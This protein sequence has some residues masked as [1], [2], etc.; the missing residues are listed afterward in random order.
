MSLGKKALSGF[1]WTLVTNISLKLV[2]LSVGI[3]LARILGPEDFGLIAMIMVFFD[4]SQ[5]LVDSGFSQAL[6]RE[7]NLSESDKST[8][9]SLNVMIAILLY[10]VLWF[11]APMIAKFYNNKNLVDLTRFMGVSIIFQSFTLVQ[12]ATLTHSLMFK[13]VTKITVAASVTSGLIGIILAVNGFGVW[14]LAF[15]YISLS[16]FLSVFYYFVNPWVPKMFVRSSSFHKLFGFGS[17]LLAAGI[18]NKVYQNIYKMI[19]GKFFAAATLG[20]YTQAK[21]Y[22]NQVTQSA[23]GT[24]QTVTYPILSKAQKDPVRLKQAYRKIIMAS[25]FVIFP[26]TIGL[27]VLAEPLILTL[28]GEKWM[29]SIPFLQLICVSGALYHLHS[30]NLNVLKVMGR[31]DLFLKLEVIKK[32]NITIAIIIGIQFGIWGLLVSSV[33]SSYIALFI[34]MYYTQRFIN[35]SYGEQFRDLLPI[36]LLSIPMLVIVYVFLSSTNFSNPIS[37]FLGASLGMLV[38]LA[39]SLIFKSTALGYILNILSTKY[40]ILKKVNV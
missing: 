17:K 23:V 34:N 24:L 3:V 38:Y 31:S 33:I 10:V 28:V 1:S 13:K 25:S 27:A 21:L 19:I 30:I 29:E 7:E 36:V 35:Y 39:V 20:F 9:F 26:L 16:I 12:R 2:S 8:A 22:V 5:S 32:V 14:S 40:P 15:K 11:S 6:I 4:I 18:L 37:L